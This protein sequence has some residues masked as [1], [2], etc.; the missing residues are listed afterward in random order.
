VLALRLSGNM[1]KLRL[2]KV[3]G[4]FWLLKMRLGAAAASTTAPRAR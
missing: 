3:L 2:W 4:H 1:A